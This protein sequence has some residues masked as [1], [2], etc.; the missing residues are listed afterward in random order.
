MFSVFQMREEFHASFLKE[1][2][3]KPRRGI[4]VDATFFPVMIF[5]KTKRWCFVV[6][7]DK[8]FFAAAE[9]RR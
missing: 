7:K 6:Q 8:T 1:F 9:S 3:S 4:G 5:K 2:F